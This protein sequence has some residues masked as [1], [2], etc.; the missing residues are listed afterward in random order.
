MLS[1]IAIVWDRP[2]AAWGL[3]GLIALI[4]IHEYRRSRGRRVTR[5]SLSLQMAA[6]LLLVAALMGPS[7]TVHN[8]G[9][10]LLIID[11]VSGS[12]RG[13]SGQPLDLPV[14]IDVDRWYFAET[15][16]IDAFDAGINQSRIAMPLQMA[17]D[18]TTRDELAGIVIRTDGQFAHGGWQ[19]HARALG[20]AGVPVTIL[21]YDTPPED[22]QI[23][24]A[25]I[26]R[27]GEQAIVT[28]TLH[29]RPG[30]RAVPSCRFDSTG[31]WLALDPVRFAEGMTDVTVFAHGPVADRGPTVCRLRVDTYT[32]EGVSDRFPENDS[33]VVTLPSIKDRM[34]ILADEYGRWGDSLITVDGMEVESRP[35][36][37][38]PLSQEDLSEFACVLL[39]GPTFHI[40]ARQPREALAGY[41]RN[42]GGLI[43]V[44][45]GPHGDVT[46]IDDP[47]N[48]VA[49]LVADT[50]ERPALDVTLVLDVSASMGETSDSGAS[51][52]ELATQ[53]AVDIQRFL[54]DNDRLAAVTFNNDAALVYE[55]GDA[56]PDFSALGRALR[57]IQPAE[58]T[59]ADTGLEWALARPAEG[60]RRRMIILLTDSRTEPF[61]E[62]PLAE[63]LRNEG[64]QLG[65]I[66]LVPG[67]GEDV[68]T[69]SSVDNLIVATEGRMYALVGRDL[70]ISGDRKHL[71]ELFED[72][73]RWGKGD[74]TQRGSFEA[75]TPSPCPPMPPLTQYL[76]AIPNGPDPTVLAWV[77]DHP[78]LATRRAG[79]GQC[80]VLAV[81]MLTGQNVAWYN[82]ER[83]GEIMN[84]LV[85]VTRRPSR[86]DRF[87]G[88]VVRADGGKMELRV[89]AMTERTPSEGLV[90]TAWQMDT[91][92][93]ETPLGTLSPRGAGLYAVAV[94]MSEQET[95]LEVRQGDSAVLQLTSRDP[96]KAEFSSLGANW[97]VINHLAEL[98]GGSVATDLSGE[99]V[100]MDLTGRR[101]HPIGAIV[102]TAALV[103]ML[104]EWA[105]TA[106]RRRTTSV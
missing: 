105:L 84:W 18:A 102:L 27:D 65:V 90:L 58:T 89:Q 19:A 36:M 60:D 97:P 12:T 82:S 2:W 50:S 39:V 76:R 31:E 72:M 87:R 34:L 106:F 66:K 74:I 20:Q 43:I 57:A 48:Q 55:S 23:A 77:G 17:L 25:D 16:A 86:D 4:F 78:I 11:D 99:N 68:E 5:V 59:H 79:L 13:Q 14:E 38:S 44:G 91:D 24:R 103:T 46:D 35:L 54:T 81:P 69:V 33:T 62:A 49:P 21:P 42:G 67:W 94:D 80:A 6:W 104:L 64:A 26:Q 7:I 32:A 52:Y 1:S 30:M 56:A 92:G 10:V 75:T 51:L 29:G 3:L 41:V 83:T 9:K 71:A 40:P 37:A 101:T 95:L 70:L 98:T 53:A 73:V 96:I 47:L 100:A 45:L 15:V 63:A 61:D 22:V 8:G 85:A 93:R 28:M 88:Q